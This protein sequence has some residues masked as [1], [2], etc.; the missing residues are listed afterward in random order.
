MVLLFNCFITN[1]SS[2]GGHWEA[3][4]ANGVIG[5]TQ[6]RGNLKTENKVDIAKYTLSSLSKFYP[7]KRAIVKIQLDEDYYSKENELEL[8]NFI[9]EEFKGIDLIYSNK[10]NLIQQ[11][12]IDTYSLI[13]DDLIHYCC[14]HDHVA[15]NDSIEY[16]HDLIESI[17]Q[18]HKG[19]YITVAYSNWSEFIRTA[20]YGYIDHYDYAPTKP[21]I[22]YKL[23]ENYFSFNGYCYDSMHIISKNL[24]EDWFLKHKWDEA[25]YLFKPDT[26]KSGHIEL[27]R[28]DGVGII[29]LGAIR[30]QIFKDPTHIQKIIIPYKELARHFDGHFYQGITNDQVPSL[31]IPEGFFKNDIK[32]RYGYDDR[33]EGWVN[34]NP[35]AEHYYAADK[36]GMDYKFTLKELPLFWKDK[37][38]VIDS[39][40]NIDEEEMIQYRLKSILEMIYT[41]AHIYPE[42]YHQYI[43]EELEEKIL[44]EYL[45][46]YPEYQI[47]ED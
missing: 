46:Q 15:L 40:S 7:W 31:D 36:N 11:D 37:I 17:R 14:N 33:K 38:S 41:S 32:I 20:K 22:N 24:Y 5:V 26:F 1:K 45:K 18:N 30:N 16:V 9:R 2:T 8:E 3:M 35:K 28:T 42:K 19:E 6:D 47:Y 34:I 13:N 29:D 21:N 39:N 12:W 10:R 23:E 44:N 25:Y 27:P 4:R 43:E